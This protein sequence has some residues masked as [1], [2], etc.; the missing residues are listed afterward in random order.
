[1]CVFVASAPAS[2]RE[3]M[4]LK[5]RKADYE[6]T[7]NASYHGSKGEHQSRKDTM[8]GRGSILHT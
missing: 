5:E 2:P 6:S 4:A 3:M 7:G 1:M 8:T